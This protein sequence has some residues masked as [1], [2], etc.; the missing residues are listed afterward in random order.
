MNK[1]L[2]NFILI[3]STVVI[4]VLALYVFDEQRLLYIEL[5][6][7]LYVLKIIIPLIVISHIGI[8]IGL[9]YLI[10]RK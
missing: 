2:V 10:N 3:L 7:E 8:C 4:C 9:W 6:T 1:K 5:I